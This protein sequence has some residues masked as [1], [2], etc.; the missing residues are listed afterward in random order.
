V[1]EKSEEEASARFGKKR[2]SWIMRL[3]IRDGRLQGGAGA[4]RRRNQ[5]LIAT[6]EFHHALL[7][8]PSTLPYFPCPLP[9]HHSVTCSDLKPSTVIGQGERPATFRVCF[10]AHTVRLGRS[11]PADRDHTLLQMCNTCT[12]KFKIP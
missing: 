2:V 4:P 7:I 10:P 11:R 6:L 5:V 12:S 1:E 8:N 9:V 3:E